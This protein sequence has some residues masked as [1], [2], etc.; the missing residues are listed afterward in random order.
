M[1]GVSTFLGLQTSLRGL[2][3]QQRGLDVT[4]HNVANSNTV[5]YSRQE[6]I[7]APSQ[8]FRI[9][10][11]GVQDG[12]AAD[13]GT[14]VD[15][16]EYRRI[17]DLFLDIQYRAQSTSLGS[18]E[19]KAKSLDQAELAFSEPGENGIA[20]RLGRFWSAWAD[21]ANAAD[22]PA[23]RQSL[24]EQARSLA[25]A[26]A[27]LDSQLA[28]VKT[29]SAAQYASIT[30]AGGEVDTIAREIAQLNVS[31]ANAIGSGS[32]PNDL[33]DRRDL[34]LD[35]LSEYGQVTVTDLGDGRI[36]VGFGDAANPLVASTSVDWPQTLTNPG[37]KLGALLEV[38]RTGGTIDQYRVD[39]NVTV[40]ALANAVNALHSTGGGANFFAF[41]AGSAASTLTVAVTAAGVRAS[42]SGAASANEIALAIAG[43]SGGAP[44]QA[45]TA[46]VT[47]I[48]NEVRESS[49]QES[50]ART[51]RNAVEDRRQSTSGVSLDEEMSNL[52]RFQRAY[53]ASSRT[54]STMDEAL[55]V[56]INRTGRVGL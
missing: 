43:L 32:Q 29:Q 33:L 56:L 9:P 24:V 7:L 17:R 45:Y 51:L 6:A 55:D 23:A 41:T 50:A 54:L 21:L 12:G 18:A 47:R 15:V 14:G 1:A 13:L 38:S 48:G 35:Q 4:G 37:G 2:L 46:L 10:A 39:L 28:A 27:S 25:S 16:L 19:Q 3:A 42:T 44:D 31:I 11:S 53:Q 5:G 49:R 34:L 30:A 8:A 40:E 52:I 20:D 26:F 22:N 36:D